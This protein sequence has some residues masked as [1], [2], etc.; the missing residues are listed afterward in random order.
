MTTVPKDLSS[1]ISVFSVNVIIFWGQNTM[2]IGIK[3]MMGV[4]AKRV[5]DITVFQN[6][7]LE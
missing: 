7:I 5:C 3:E 2:L 6:F 4:G 1:L